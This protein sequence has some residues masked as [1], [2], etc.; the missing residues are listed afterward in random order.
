MGTVLSTSGIIIIS[1]F[2]S[3]FLLAIIQSLGSRPVFSLSKGGKTWIIIVLLS[4]T[5]S[6]NYPVQNV[7]STGI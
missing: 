6:Q 7:N 2:P 1:N 4:I 5:F 3:H